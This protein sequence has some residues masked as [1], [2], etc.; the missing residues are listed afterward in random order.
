MDNIINI[1]SDKIS[2]KCDNKCSYVYDYPSTNLVAKKNKNMI[3][4]INDGIEPVVK[5]N[6]VNYMVSSTMFVSPS[7]HKFNNNKTDGEILIEHMPIQGGKKMYVCIPLIESYSFSSASISISLIIESIK[8]NTTEEN[9]IIRITT[10]MFTLNTFIPQEEFYSYNGNDLNNVNAD[11]VVFGIENAIPLNQNSFNSLTELIKP[12]IIQMKGGDLF[13][14]DKGTKMNSETAV[15]AFDEEDVVEEDVDEEDIVEE[16][17][18]EE[19]VDEED[20]VEEDVVEDHVVEDKPKVVDDKNKNS[21]WDNKI[22]S[23]ILTIILNCLFF[24]VVFYIINFTL[25]Y[26]LSGVNDKLY[27]PS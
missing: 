18:V 3:T 5:Y 26:L 25:N 6:N 14:N 10:A 20:V 27:F 22:I 16:D 12:I 9:D 23:T 1:S 21:F 4:I 2:G 8:A 11:F 13:F 7:I 24:F 17:V 19:D 15:D